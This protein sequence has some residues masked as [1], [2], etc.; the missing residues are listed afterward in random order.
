MAKKTCVICNS[1]YATSDQVF[2]V[3]FKDGEKICYC[4]I[5]LSEGPLS[6]V[7]EEIKAIKNVSEEI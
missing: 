2:E 4:V 3:E 5:C 1:T 6:E 7:P